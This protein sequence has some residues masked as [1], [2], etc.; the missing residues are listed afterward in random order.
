MKINILFFL[1][2]A[3]TASFI[4]SCQNSTNPT[5]YDSNTRLAKRLDL[6]GDSLTNINSASGK[7]SVNGAIIGVISSENN[8]TYL[9]AFGKADISTNTLLKRSDEYRIGTLTESFLAT[10]TLILV[11]DG[12]LSL[13]DKI[14]QYIDLPHS[15]NY[16]SIRDLLQH[17]S[18]FPDFVDSVDFYQ[19]FE[20]NRVFSYNELVDFVYK[21]KDYYIPINEPKYSHFN[22]YLLGKILEN[23]SEEKLDYLI[24]R[25]VLDP[26]SLE[27]TFFNN[28]SDFYS[29][30]YSNGYELSDSKSFIDVTQNRNYSWTWASAN[31]TS[32][33]QDLIK[34]VFYLNEG[35]LLNRTSQKEM[36]DFTYFYDINNL[37]VY[38][39]AGMMRIG[40]FQGF[41]G[42]VSGYNISLYY[43][44]NKDATIVVFTNSE[45]NNENLIIQI[46]QLL[47]PGY[48]AN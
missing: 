35:T 28:K 24:K 45:N 12:L 29:S 44:P 2:I 30:S 40:T 47:Y 9:R 13:D 37:N 43:L 27:N 39:G 25:K 20:P 32:I 31:M 33:T 8:F 41:S 19:K 17:K 18:S 38:L 10:L 14:N 22:Y 21:Q 23:V 4:S 1:I 7:P 5:N 15:G 26:L 36:Q 48:R 42:K 16:I 3:I 6:I 34:W 11:E 46:A